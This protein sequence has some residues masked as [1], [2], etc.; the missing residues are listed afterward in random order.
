MQVFE[1]EAD[2]YLA[3]KLDY[4]TPEFPFAFYY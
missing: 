4:G 1:V 2:E 3:S